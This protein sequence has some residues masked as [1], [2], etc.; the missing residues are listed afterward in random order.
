MA[1]SAQAVRTE[2]LAGRASGS[3]GVQ[4]TPAASGGPRLA[5]RRSPQNCQGPCPRCSVLIC[6]STKDLIGHPCAGRLAAWLGPDEWLIIDEAGD[7][8]GDLRKA[9]VMHSA[10]GCFPPQTRL[11]WSRARAR[12]PRS[13]RA[14]RRISAMAALPIGRRE[15]D[16]VG[17][18]RSGDH[19]HRRSRISGSSCWR[20]FS[21][22]AFL[23]SCRKARGTASPEA[24]VGHR[25][26]PVRRQRSK[27][28]S[29][30]RSRGQTG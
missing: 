7:P 15:P 17:Q 2:P 9:K 21:T 30:A 5:A 26:Q 3:A 4:I 10:V 12:A 8:L 11:S 24:V 13:N 16:G 22:Y 20:S 18:D 28:P 19:P 6:R 29:S 1:K 14:V 25:R 27:L 23:S